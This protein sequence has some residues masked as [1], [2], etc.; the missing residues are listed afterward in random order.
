MA[1]DLLQEKAL[2]L[3]DKTKDNTKL[4]VIQ[5]KIQSDSQAMQQQEEK[6]LLKAAQAEVRMYE[7]LDD[8][9]SLKMA[10]KKEAFLR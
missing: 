6:V 2:I 9:D 8:A 1:Q 7:A 10:M 5:S 4:A 3:D